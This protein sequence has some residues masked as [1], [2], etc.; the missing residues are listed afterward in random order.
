MSYSLPLHHPVNSLRPGN[1]YRNAVTLSAFA[2][3]LGAADTIRSLLLQRQTFHDHYRGSG[4]WLG[5]RHL[6]RAA[7]CRL[8][9][10]TTFGAQVRH[11]GHLRVRDTVSG[12]SP[13][14]KTYTDLR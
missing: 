14:D 5:H 2:S 3:E 11:Y 7:L 4:S 8:G 10:A 9:S 1:H 6:A 12:N 13:K